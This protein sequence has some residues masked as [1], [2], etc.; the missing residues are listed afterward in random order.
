MSPSKHIKYSLSA[1]NETPYYRNSASE[2]STPVS[3][4]GND[5]SDLS[6]ES[7]QHL[8]S[9]L[10]ITVLVTAVTAV[11]IRFVIKPD[12]NCAKFLTESDDQGDVKLSPLKVTGASLLTGVIVALL[13]FLA[14]K[15][16]LL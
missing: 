2:V 12:A 14:H 8:T 7:M 13:T 1:M 16:S 6:D 11:I 9:Y 5:K 3:D 10:V 15:V 4:S